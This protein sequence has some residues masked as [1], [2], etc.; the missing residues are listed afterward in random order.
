MYIF[1]YFRLFYTHLKNKP[2]EI[3]EINLQE[4]YFK[5]EYLCRAKLCTE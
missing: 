4:K 2:H 3:V 1:K 5:T